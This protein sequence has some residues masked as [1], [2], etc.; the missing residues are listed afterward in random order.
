MSPKVHERDERRDPAQVRRR[1]PTPGSRACSPSRSARAGSRTST[2]CRGSRKFADDAGLPRALARGEAREQ[3]AA[4]GVARGTQDVSVDPSTLFDAQCKRIHE[5]KR[6]H[7]EPASRRLALRAH[8]ARRARRR[9]RRGRCCSPG[10][11]P[12]LPGGKAHRPPRPRPSRGDPRGG[13]P[14]RKDSSRVVF[15]PDFNVKNAQRIYPAVGFVRA[16]STAGMEASG[17]GNMKFAPQR[18]AHDWHA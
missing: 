12:R 8:S 1:S 10:R 18:R 7:L 11:R 14:S 6:Q 13:P 5:Y 4:R 16:D 15:V 3:G 17:T 2:S 9:R